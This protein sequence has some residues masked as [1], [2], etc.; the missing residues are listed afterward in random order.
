MSNC[1][2]SSFQTT[3]FLAASL[4]SA[5]FEGR[6][7]MTA[8]DVEAVEADNLL[9]LILRVMAGFAAADVLVAI[10]GRD[11]VRD[12]CRPAEA[13]TEVD[14]DMRWAFTGRAVLEDADDPEVEAPADVEAK[15]AP[16]SGGDRLATV[17]FLLVSAATTLVLAT[18]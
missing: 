7:P 14:E 12:V 4:G 3:P 1:P 9:L 2:A 18:A 13:E 8:V 15:G 10:A 16:K 6:L 5:A 11:E 17:R